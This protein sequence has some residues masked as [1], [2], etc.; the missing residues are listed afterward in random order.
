MPNRN[1]ILD[2]ITAILKAISALLPQLFP[3]PAYDKDPKELPMNQDPITMVS[4][5]NTKGNPHGWCEGTLAHRRAMYALAKKICQEEG[6]Y[7][8]M[9][10]DLL[11]TVYGE[12]GFNQW[13]INTQSKDYGVAQFSV[14][15]Y[16]KEYNMTPQD[17]VEQPERCLRIM[18][19]NFKAGR[20]SNWIAYTHR[21][22]HVKNIKTLDPTF[23]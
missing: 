17:C 19:K 21:A 10:R 8:S 11:L 6:L 15:Y 23:T 20:Q 1:A 18:A 2:K 7:P 12:S 22:N 4:G 13:C 14:R 16:C 9:A 3:Q 5:V